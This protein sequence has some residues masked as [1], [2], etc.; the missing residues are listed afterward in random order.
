MSRINADGTSSRA[1][2]LVHAEC[3]TMTWDG[4]DT[5]F[6]RRLPDGSIG[7]RE[8]HVPQNLRRE[9]A[10]RVCGRVFR[11]TDRVALQAVLG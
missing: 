2:G 8:E 7:R 4:Y 9:F 11:T 10:C 6:A 1:F 5:G 3:V